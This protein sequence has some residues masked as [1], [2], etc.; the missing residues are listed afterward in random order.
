ML[1]N[2]D[3][4]APS[5]SGMESPV[6]LLRGQ[7]QTRPGLS[8]LGDD[9]AD[10]TLGL[11]DEVAA[12]VQSFIIPEREGMLVDRVSLDVEDNHGDERFTCLYHPILYGDA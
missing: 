10:R 1:S 8:D 3:Q 2:T 7:Y 6:E 9:D 5:S 4:D 12:H 11:S